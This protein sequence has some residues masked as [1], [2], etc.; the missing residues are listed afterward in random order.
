VTADSTPDHQRDARAAWR[1][2][3]VCGLVASLLL[4]APLALPGLPE[5]GYGWNAAMGSGIAALIVLSAMTWLGRAPGSTSLPVVFF[6]RF[7]VYAA[8]IAASFA[9]VHG[10]ALL[11]Q[12]PVLLAEFRLGGPPSMLAGV[13][14]LA[15]MALLAT[16][17]S[18]RCRRI[19]ERRLAGIGHAALAVLAAALTLAHLVAR[20][21][22]AIG[23]RRLTWVALL[24]MA[25]LVTVGLRAVHQ[26]T[27]SERAELRDAPLARLP[28]RRAALLAASTLAAAVLVYAAA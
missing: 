14:A 18:Q 5:G 3:L 27:G 7:H 24:A 6:H 1:Y 26:R 21:Y 9:V 15:A 23:S 19:H 25:L 17:P 20:G 4:L 22:A 8:R 2:G 12:E 10:V 11:V 13:C 28:A 16:I